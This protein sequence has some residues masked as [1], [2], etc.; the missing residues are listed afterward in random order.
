MFRVL[1]SF[2]GFLRRSGISC[3]RRTMLLWLAVVCVAI[4]R[5]ALVPIHTIGSSGMHD[6][7][8]IQ[9]LHNRPNHLE[10]MERTQKWQNTR[11]WMSELESGKSTKYNGI[12]LFACRATCMEEMEQVWGGKLQLHVCVCVYLCQTSGI[13]GSNLDICTHTHTP[14]TTRIIIRV[15]TVYLCHC[16]YYQRNSAPMQ[17]NSL[18]HPSHRSIDIPIILHR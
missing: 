13:C 15:F 9:D 16:P 12:Y 8:S 7:D 5:W 4:H 11:D 18:C 14:R 2:V 3:V 1:H 10:T 6:F 17:P